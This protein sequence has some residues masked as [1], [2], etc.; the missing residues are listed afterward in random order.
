M[1]NLDARR[2]WGYAV[3]YVRAM[4]LMMQQPVPDDYVVATGETH[5]V[6]EFCEAAF[7]QLGLDYRQYVTQ[8][9]QFYRPAEIHLLQGDATLARERL[10]W[11]PTIGFKE[12]VRMMVEHDLQAAER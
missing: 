2:D 10:G 4:Y 11:R 8:Q 5:S 12:L 1:G 9:A 6:R 3:D 7:G